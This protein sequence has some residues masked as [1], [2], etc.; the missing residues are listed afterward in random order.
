[1]IAGIGLWPVSTA[2]FFSNGK[3]APSGCSNTLIMRSMTCSGIGF[4]R[5]RLRCLHMS[6]LVLTNMMP[7]PQ[8]TTTWHTKHYKLFTAKQLCPCAQI[9][10][11][12]TLLREV[13]EALAHASIMEIVINNVDT[14]MTSLICIESVQHPLLDLS[15]QGV[16]CCLP[17]DR[18]KHVRSTRMRREQRIEADGMDSQR[19]VF[20]LMV[21]VVATRGHELRRERRLPS[22]RKPAQQHQHFHAATDCTIPETSKK[23]P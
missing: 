7:K 21:F 9:S 6:T 5:W 18:I 2:V 13:V 17:L 15:D 19:I 22:A 4:G 8:F 14:L 16:L 23:P 11:V 10:S 20:F 1:M 12:R 3:R